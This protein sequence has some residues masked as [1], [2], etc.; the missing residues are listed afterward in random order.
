MS[1]NSKQLNIDLTINFGIFN[2]ISKPMDIL[3][4]I[5]ILRS[6]SQV[7]NEHI[8]YLVGLHDKGLIDNLSE[9]SDVILTLSKLGFALN[10]VADKKLNELHFLI[11]VKQDVLDAEV[12]K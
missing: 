4:K 7:I 5:E 3:R 6:E 2:S 9:V 11:E 10:E 12:I 8:A 1:K